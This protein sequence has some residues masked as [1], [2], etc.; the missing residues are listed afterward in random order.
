MTKFTSRGRR[1]TRRSPLPLLTLYLSHINSN[2]SL[3][4]VMRDMSIS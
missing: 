2:S 4:D 3:S 1:N